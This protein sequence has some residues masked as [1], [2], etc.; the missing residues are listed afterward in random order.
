MDS[1]KISR[2]V[3]GNKQTKKTFRGVFS[4]DMLPGARKRSDGLYIVNLDNSDQAGSHWVC[5]DLRRGK[6]EKSAYFD[7]YGL[8][9]PYA[10]FENFM[11][12]CYT[13][14]TKQ[15]QHPLSTSCGQ[16][17]LYFVLRRNQGWGMKKLVW[18]FGKNFLANDHIMN[19]V[20]RKNFKTE[21]RVIDR[22]FL[23]SQISQLMGENE[24]WKRYQAQQTDVRNA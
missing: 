24:I 18:P 6:G 2:K 14:N 7:S 11:N 19:S 20:V 22:T 3:K 10:A 1:V 21:A 9:P 16:W 4:A 12:N 23:Q 5:I 13:H 17:C 8:P 15:L